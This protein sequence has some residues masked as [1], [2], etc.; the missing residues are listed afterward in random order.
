MEFWN[1]FRIILGT[2]VATTTGIVGIIW[3]HKNADTVCTIVYSAYV[4]L[5]IILC[6]LVLTAHELY[7]ITQV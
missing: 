7:W 1:Y 3:C 5:N 2:V 6:E 4:L